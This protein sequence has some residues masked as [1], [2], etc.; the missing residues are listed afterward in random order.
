[1]FMKM[2]NNYLKLKNFHWLI[3]DLIP[4]KEANTDAIHNTTQIRHVI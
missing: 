3:L 2:I 4:T 1:M